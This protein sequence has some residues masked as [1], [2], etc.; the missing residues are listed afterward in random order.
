MGY[1]CPVCGDPQADGVHL[2]NHLAFTAL[3]RGGDHES[4]LEDNVPDW[5]ERGEEGLAAAVT[6]LAESAEYPQVFEDTTGE[7]GR[8]NEHD[9][10]HGQPARGAEDVPVDVGALGDPAEAEEILAEAREMTRTRRRGGD[11]GSEGGNEPSADNGTGEESANE[12][13]TEANERSE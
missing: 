12:T 7:G 3:V 4:W 2:A 5:E 10:R 6:D 11:N 1:R 13:G 8:G 9:H